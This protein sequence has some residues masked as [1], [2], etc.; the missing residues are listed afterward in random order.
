MSNLVLAK[1]SS[2]K[3]VKSFPQK[4]LQ[5]TVIAVLASIGIHGALGLLL[6]YLG[7]SSQETPAKKTVQLVQLTPEEQS[8]LPQMSPPSRSPSQLQ[9]LNPLPGL[10]TPY[11]PL[12]GSAFPLGL[13]PVNP[14]SNGLANKNLSALPSNTTRSQ[15]TATIPSTAKKPQ[16][17]KDQ[18][19]TEQKLAPYQGSMRISPITQ[20]PSARELSSLVGSLNP[21]PPLTAMP[22]LPPPP[23][24]P[25]DLG[26]QPGT[27]IAKAPQFGA[28][29][30]SAPAP[31]GTRGRILP[32]LVSPDIT[33]RTRTNYSSATPSPTSSPSSP[34]QELSGINP[35]SAAPS[36]PPAPPLSK[37]NGTENGTG[38]SSD[39]KVRDGINALA[40]I[41]SGSDDIKN[42]DPIVGK[43]PESACASRAT[44]TSSIAAKVDNN[45]TIVSV[46]P[47]PASNDILDR[48]AI[49][50]VSERD[51]E[52]TNK[53]V[54][55]IFPVKF[56]YD[57]SVCGRAA[58]PK[59]A[60]PRNS[61]TPK[62]TA[63]APN[64]KTPQDAPAPKK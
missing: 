61:A 46:K 13:S 60:E 1:N 29:T 58:V 35:A 4:L 37:P 31:S 50:A 17:N 16:A 36:L 2:H 26:A 48:A 62:P 44:G 7:T 21:A 53:T 42:H 59:D 57:S 15:T 52:V 5:P 45:G 8:R 28:P 30:S 24:Y 34:S 10:S 6:P 39:Q 33:V 11:P 19:I 55:H 63:E 56:E 32:E 38:T 43:Y 25:S 22:P 54:T 51:M 64:T 20:R 47:A 41:S 9:S 12:T 3:P 40:A 18:K 27:P 23:L 49:A 14:P